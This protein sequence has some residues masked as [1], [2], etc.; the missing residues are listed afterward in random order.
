MFLKNYTWP[1]IAHKCAAIYMFFLSPD[2]TF[3]CL[4]TALKSSKE[5]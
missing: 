5:G 4:V 2:H 3:S 1:Y